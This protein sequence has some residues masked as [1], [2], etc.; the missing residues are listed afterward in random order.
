MIEEQL[1]FIFLQQYS[2]SAINN[3]ITCPNI[4][5]VSEFNSRIWHNRL[6]NP[7][8]S[9]LIV[10]TKSI[11]NIAVQNKTS[12]DSHCTVCHLTNQKRLSFPFHSYNL[13]F[14]QFQTKNQCVRSDNVQDFFCFKSIIHQTFCVKTSHQNSI[15]ERKHQH[16]LNVA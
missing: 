5:F 16:I 14:T 10:L 1:N 6:G 12:N 3:S 13:N 2:V 8:E 15:I 4:N 7:S 11:Q 9:R